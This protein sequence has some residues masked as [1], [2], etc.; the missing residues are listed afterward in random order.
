MGV[1]VNEARGDE[2]SG[3]VDLAGAGTVD[4]ADRDD[5]AVG[6]G[7]VTAVGSPPRPSTSVPLRMT[8]S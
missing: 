7:D 5:D 1:E 6:Y 8:K 3:R 2:Q 4:G